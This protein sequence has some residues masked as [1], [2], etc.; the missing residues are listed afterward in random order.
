MSVLKP[1]M[2]VLKCA[3]IWLEALLA[4]VIP[5]INWQVTVED[6]MVN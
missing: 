2:A 6:V 1:E 4:L 5:A 3:T